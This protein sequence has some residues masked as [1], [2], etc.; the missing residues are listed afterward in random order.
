MKKTKKIRV[1]NDNTRIYQQ[2]FKGKTVTIPAKSYIYMD[3]DDAHEF[4]SAFVP[5]KVDSHGKLLKSHYRMIR[6]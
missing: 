3:I 5:A 4:K 1:Y 2:S 6:I